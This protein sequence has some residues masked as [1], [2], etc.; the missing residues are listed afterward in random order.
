M[1]HPRF[2]I[3][4]SLAIGLVLIV[5]LSGNSS[6]S[7]GSSTSSTDPGPQATDGAATRPIAPAV[8][9]IFNTTLTVDSSSV[10]LS[11]LFWGTTVNNEVHM[12]RGEADAVNA[13]PA[14]VLVW[15][16]AMAGE[17][18]N[19]LTET[20]YDTWYGSANHALTSERQF[21]EMCKAIRCTSVVQLPAEIDDP[22]LAEQ[23]VNYTLVNLSFVPSYWMIGN[24]PELWSHW[25]V[26]WKN[27]ATQYTTGPTPTQF[28][29][30]VLDYVK[31]IRDVDPTTPILGLPAS[32]CTCGFWTFD[33]WI[34][35]V[36]QV[37]GDKIQAV[38]FHE[39]PAGWLGTGNGSLQAFYGTLQGAAGI[40]TRMAAAR[41]AVLSACP[42][43]NVS[44]WIS[45]IGSALSWSTYG[46]Y[47]IGF[48]GSLSLASQ[49]TQAM[50]VNLTNVDLFATELATT[51]SWFDPTG[52]A[53]TD[54]ALYTSIF[55]HLGTQAFAVN[56]TGLGHTLYA[57]DTITPSDQGRQDLLV[58]NDNIVNP[59]S[60]TPRFAG[61]LTS[62]PVEAWSWNGSIHY[63]PS[64]HTT[65]VEPYTPTP[66]PNEFPSGLPGTYVLPPQ[67]MVLFESYPAGGTYVRILENGVPSP[68]RW[69]ASVDGQL[70]ATTADNISLLLPTGPHPVGSVPIPLPI[71]GKELVPVE[72]LGPFVA[73]PAYVS[74][75]YTNVTI[76][77]VN[78]WSV[79]V[80]AT[81]A[82]GGTVQPD[83]GWWNESAPL[84]LTATPALGYALV[85][86][87][88]WGPGSY[89]GSG[90]TITVAPT[91]RVVEKARFAIGQEV[92]MFETGLPAGTPW[93]VVVRE[94]ETSSNES[95][96]TIYET[97]GMYG[98]TVNPVP[99]YRSLPKNGGFTVTG[100]VQLVKIQFIPITPP[101]PAFAVTF[102]VSGLPASTAVSITV[103]GAT[104]STV[105]S[106]P[107]ILPRFQLLNG[108][109]AYHVGYVAG[110]HADVPEKTFVVLGGPLTVV[111]PFV[112]T[113]YSVTWEAIGTRQGM[114]W[115]VVVNGQ[116]S[117]AA[118]AW[119]SASLPN[120][121]YAY[122]I[123]LPANYSASP[124]SGGIA[125]DGSGTEVI[126]RFSLA[127]FPMRFEAAGPAAT[128]AWSVR[129]GNLTQRASSGASSFLAPNGT[130]TFDVHPPEGYYA[131]PSHGNVTVAGPA[132][133]MVIQFHPSSLQPSAS[134]VAQLTAG[135]ISASVWIGA[136]VF[137]GYVV[138]RG[139]TRRDG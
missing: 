33:Q 31:V 86:W 29:N 131:V 120:G 54:Y 72:R 121:S 63:T 65:W 19:P 84:R 108:S 2:P 23:I 49:M 1:P 81:P 137:G 139:L 24:E 113:V 71:D 132:S 9:T 62:S 6:S 129:L 90:R 59:I 48:S 68:T 7:P 98:F 43:C 135:A 125:I 34:A 47:A 134:L 11:S 35:G 85:G 28:A 78:Q 127:Q 89:N 80:S 87:S 13:T 105:M 36:L 50:D 107:Q 53:R 4:R 17:D 46:P 64:N 21:V 74:G 97:P 55:D 10:N 77:F 20:H 136:S 69:Y 12:F 115:S 94:L 67:S 52:H 123:Q 40:P 128:N 51:N 95:F 18:Y 133:P 45:E 88:G 37:T 73:S 5:I 96:L 38:A 8:G 76:D 119:V 16:G 42:G 56:L 106:D 57:I 126:L 66:I 109:Y 32:G 26:P 111:V 100:L 110:W 61:P 114:H 99:G 122:A 27:W 116:E 92:V 25:K 101:P 70:H 102:Q 104:Q 75:R 103:R 82:E 41:A 14:H 130:Y 3:A 91:G 30:E 22:V 93:S 15:P 79:N 112:R 44:V 60:F 39:Y 58:V 138:F 83:V 117:V 124:R 118:S